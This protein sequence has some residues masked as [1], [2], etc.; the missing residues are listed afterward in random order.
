MIVDNR[1]MDQ[2]QNKGGLEEI[3][4][5]TGERAS[6][7]LGK[8]LK[9]NHLPAGVIRAVAL[10]QRPPTRRGLLIL[11]KPSRPMRPLITKH[12]LVDLRTSVKAPTQPQE[13]TGDSSSPDFRIAVELERELFSRAKT[14]EEYLGEIKKLEELI[15]DSDTESNIVELDREVYDCIFKLACSKR[16]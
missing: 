3:D 7:P 5:K 4:G 14:K 11:S 13:L 2:E 1:T 10:S 15:R 9:Y 6:I 12:Q 16:I 8:I